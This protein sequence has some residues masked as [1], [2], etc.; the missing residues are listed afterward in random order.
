MNN[1]Y[2]P[3]I[4]EGQKSVVQRLNPL[5]ELEESQHSRQAVPSSTLVVKYNDDDNDE[6]D[7]NDDDNDEKDNIDYD[8]D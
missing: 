6:E 5:Q 8:N 3:R 7:N 2:L 4:E 1:L